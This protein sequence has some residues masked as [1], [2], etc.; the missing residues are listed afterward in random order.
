[1]KRKIRLVFILV[2]LIFIPE[3]VIIIN[4]E[5]PYPA[6][7]FPSFANIPSLAKPIKKPRIKI[8]F[9]NQDS[10]EIKVSELFRTY[11]TSLASH[12]GKQSIIGYYN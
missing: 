12:S 10:L 7:L 5:Q 2:I 1:M 3:L 9:N 8:F 11:L 4:F 6:I